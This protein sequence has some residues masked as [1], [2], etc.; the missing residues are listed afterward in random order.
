MLRQ[1]LTESLV[2]GLIGAAAGLLLGVMTLRGMLAMART[3][4][5]AQQISTWI[6]L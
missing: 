6:G 1:L 5:R 2:L 4:C 3:I